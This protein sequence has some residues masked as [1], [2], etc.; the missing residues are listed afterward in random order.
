MDI[1][2]QRKWV[3]EDADPYRKK[4]DAVFV[5]LRAPHPRKRGFLKKAPLETEKHKQTRAEPF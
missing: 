1:E 5:E 3:V 2:A 4:K